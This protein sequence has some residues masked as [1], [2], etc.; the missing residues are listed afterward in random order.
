MNQNDELRRLLCD[1][2][3]VLK[4][5]QN[6]AACGCFS[7]WY[8]RDESVLNRVIEMQKK[9]EDFIVARGML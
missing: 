5:H 4:K 8:D 7:E 3:E 1:I 9:L 2:T 6:Y